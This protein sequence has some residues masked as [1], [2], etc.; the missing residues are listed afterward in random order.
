M[1]DTR[2]AFEASWD[3]Q[4]EKGWRRESQLAWEIWQ[5][6]INH[7]REECTKVCE[8]YG[9][10]YDNEWNRKLGVANDLKDACEECAAAIRARSEPS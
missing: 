4:C 7:E 5:A 9:S 3:A 2:A 8:D 1:T 10:S 6:A